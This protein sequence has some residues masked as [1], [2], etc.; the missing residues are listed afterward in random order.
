MKN[1]KNVVGY[2]L[3]TAVMLLIF[4]PLKTRIEESVPTYASFFILIWIIL[5]AVFTVVAVYYATQ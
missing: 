3:L 1:T 2:L 4:S 5:I